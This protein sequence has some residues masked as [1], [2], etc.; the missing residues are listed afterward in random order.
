[1][2]A[3]MYCPQFLQDQHKIKRISLLVEG[4]AKGGARRY[5]GRPDKRGFDCIIYNMHHVLSMQ[6]KKEQA[7]RKSDSSNY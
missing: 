5:L 7:V 3:T 2:A 4:G 1:M 6:Q